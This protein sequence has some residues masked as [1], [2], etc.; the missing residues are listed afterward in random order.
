MGEGLLKLY[1][2]RVNRESKIAFLG[3][4]FATLLFHFFKFANYLP[5]HDSVYNYYADQNVIGSGR[6]ALSAASAFSSFFDLPWVIGIISAVFIGLSAA[7]VEDIQNQKS[8]A[9]RACGVASCR[10]SRY[11]GDFF[12]PLHRRRVHDR[13]V[14]F[15]SRRVFFAS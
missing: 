6:W 5:N 14:S 1:R 3:G 15:R 4:F 7:V 8:R 13:D 11:Y 12:L 10:S 2:S 9:Y